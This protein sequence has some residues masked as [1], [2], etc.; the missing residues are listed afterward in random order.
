[1]KRETGIGMLRNNHTDTAI[2][3]T[4][5][6]S[7]FM[8]GRSATLTG[9]TAYNG[10]DKTNS[11]SLIVLGVLLSLTA[12]NKM[13]ETKRDLMCAYMQTSAPIKTPKC[14][15]REYM[16]V[17]HRGLKGNAKVDVLATHSHNNTEINTLSITHL[18]MYE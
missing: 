2:S 11:N 15:K 12:I 3:L 5:H 13:S 18:H 10:L 4:Y 17:F 9:L 16:V 8:S 6:T 7:I 14:R 1:M